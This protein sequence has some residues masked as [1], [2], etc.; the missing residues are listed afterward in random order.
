MYLRSTGITVCGLFVKLLI[1]LVFVC[2]SL[3]F[4]SLTSCVGY[5]ANQDFS[6]AMQLQHLPPKRTATSL[7]FSDL[8]PCL[9][10]LVF[11]PFSPLALAQWE[12]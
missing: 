6:A 8:E 1:L 11:L 9:C 12:I 5:K 10:S 4:S 2:T 7:Q 3:P